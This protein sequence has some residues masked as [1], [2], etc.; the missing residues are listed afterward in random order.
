LT[1]RFLFTCWPFVGHVFGQ[2]GIANAL[3]E[4]GHEV[5]FYTGDSAR[6]TIEGE[7]FPLFPFQR[8]DEDRAYKN[9]RALETRARWGSP[10]GRLLRT[11]R[12]WLVETIPDQV[13]DQQPLMEEWQP[14]VLVTDLSM[15][16]PIVI[17]WEEVP[18]PVAL[19]S[20]FMGPLIP[21]PDAPPWGLGFRPPRTG[22]E[23]IVAR[24]I[25]RVTELLG[26]G[27]RRRVDEL[28]S[29]HGLP[30]MGSSL[31]EFT[32]RLPLYLVGNVPE[33][34]YNRRDLPGCVHYVGSCIWHPPDPGAA[35][36]LD[37]LPA[38]YPWVHV[39]EGTLHSG[40]P[41]ILRAAVRGLAGAPMEVILTTGGERD[42]DRLGLGPLAPN[43]HVTRW[44]SHSELLPRC[45]AVVTAGGQATIMAALTAGVPLVIVPTT[46]DKPDN[47][48]RV[49]EAGVGVRLA[50]RRCTPR[51]LRAAVEEVL[52]EPG[53]RE[54]ACRIAERLAA[55]PGPPRAAELLEGLSAAGR[56]TARTDALDGAM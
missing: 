41:F 27:L 51:R 17:L 42:P 7:G 45:A 31:N 20:T 28:R 23:R 54:S 43:V 1:A 47:A 13:A 18:I 38:E 24:G 34:D 44:V 26:T 25:T 9:V 16:G 19:S 10:K 50:P 15:W 11:F 35:A 33:L 36:W 56:V 30:P 14:D 48:R 40:D 52:G 32:G 22:P 53:Y 29:E 8:V 5:A 55:A 21:G 39:T 6:A 3:R 12:D 46:W 37:E 2:M 4:G 49:V